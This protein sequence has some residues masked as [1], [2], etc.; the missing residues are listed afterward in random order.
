[1]KTSKKSVGKITD[2]PKKERGKSGFIESK[3]CSNV[4][5]NNKKPTYIKFFLIIQ[6]WQG[7]GITEVLMHYMNYYKLSYLR[8]NWNPHEDSQK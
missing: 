8:Y 7:F 6:F 4:L 1:M 3:I 2:T 5:V